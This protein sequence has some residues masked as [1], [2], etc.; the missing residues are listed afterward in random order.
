MK[1]KELIAVV[2]VVGGR[3]DNGEMWRWV[4]RWEGYGI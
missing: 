2:V 1:E 4:N 3:V